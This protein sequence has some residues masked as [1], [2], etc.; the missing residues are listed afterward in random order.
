MTATRW[1]TPDAV[2]VNCHPTCQQPTRWQHYVDEA[3][4]CAS[5]GCDNFEAENPE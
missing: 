2:C 3:N 5:C 1:M 4:L